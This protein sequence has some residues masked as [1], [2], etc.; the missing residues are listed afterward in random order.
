MPCA[1]N[2]RRPVDCVDF[3]SLRPSASEDQPVVMINRRRQAEQYLQHPVHAGRPEQVLAAHHVGDA[4]QGIV[5]HH[6]EVIAGRRL[7]AADDD[8]APGRRIGGDVADLAAGT[9][10]DLL[11]AQRAGPFHRLLHV[12]AD[13]I[14]LA[15][16]DARLAIWF[17]DL[18]RRAR[19][20]RNAIGIARPALADVTVG[21]QMRELGAALEARE[22]HAHGFK[23]VQRGAVAVEMLGLP[24]H[25]VLPVQ[26][27][28]RQILIDRRLELGPA[29]RRVDVLHAE[30]EPAAGPARHVEVHQRR[31]RMAEMQVAVRARCETENGLR[32]GGCS[33]T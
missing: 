27:E 1:R 16:C 18:P 8:V 26:P 33:A 6:R 15:S 31:E 22:G 20:D 10:P 12:E 25:R 17:L 14:G 2:S 9:Y 29:S 23:L 4:L 3:E 11:P 19:I 32:H 24:P 5:D 28:P 30:Q 13:G 7:L 21:H